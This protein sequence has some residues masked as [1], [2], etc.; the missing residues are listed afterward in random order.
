M[1]QFGDYLLVSALSLI[2][3]SRD[4]GNGGRAEAGLFLDYGV[5]YLLR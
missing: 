3:P 2:E 4:A 1:M 5:G